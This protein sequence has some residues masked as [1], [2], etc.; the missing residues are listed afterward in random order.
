MT[1]VTRPVS[2]PACDLGRPAALW[3]AALAPQ[4]SAGKPPGCRAQLAARF[5]LA[6]DRPP[7]RI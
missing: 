4:Q 7:Y 1:T 3:L 6:G 5:D 2:S